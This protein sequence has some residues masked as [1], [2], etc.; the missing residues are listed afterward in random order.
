MANVLS[1]ILSDIKGNRIAPIY[2]LCGERYPVN[3]VITALRHAVLGGEENSFNFDALL[4]SEIDVK[5]ILFAARTLPM[6]GA[7]RLVQVRDAHLFPAEAL[8]KLLPYVKEPAPTTCLLLIA[9]KADLRLKFFT[10]LKKKAVV[11]RFEPLKEHQV[12][13]WVMQEAR[14]LGIKLQPGTAER[15]SE[16]IGTDM[17]QLVSA[18]ERLSL[19][20]GPKAVIT[21]AE[22]DELLVE[23]RQRSIFDLTNAVGRGQRREALLVLRKMLENRESGVKMVMMLARHVRQLWSAR[24]LLRRGRAKNDIAAALGIHPYF[25]SD[26]L[27]QTER[28]SEHMLQRTHR[29]LFQADRRLKSSRMPEGLILEQLVLEL[30]PN[31]QQDKNLAYY[32]RNSQ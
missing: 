11:L 22:V 29:A 21:P 13:S 14:R 15:I 9:D 32:A 28:F 24:E 5:D 18:L 26:L 12:S 30:C 25:I 27:Q 3:Q 6:L 4:A 20:V 7:K 31:P 2:Y 16:A 1:D 8:N 19:Y 23:T 17:D 10:E